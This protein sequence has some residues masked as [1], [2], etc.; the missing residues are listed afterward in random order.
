MIPLL[1][2]EETPFEAVAR[3][4]TSTRERPELGYFLLA[5]LI[6]AAFGI[7]LSLV[8]WW[9]KN[10]RQDEGTPE[11]LFR[12]LCQIHRLS[13]QERQLI[14]RVVATRPPLEQSRVFL[15]RTLLEQLV[16]AG[17]PDSHAA[18]RLTARLFGERVEA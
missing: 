9:L 11:A 4:L 1:L 2:A 10:R 3:Y 17:G 18:G 6:L 14:H 8:D 16:L 7:G 12:D 5:G 13:W 15:D